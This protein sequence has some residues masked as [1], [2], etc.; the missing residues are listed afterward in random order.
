MQDHL[1][2]L[3]TRSYQ[4]PAPVDPQHTL[5]ELGLD[6]LGLAELGAELQDRFGFLVE[7]GDILPTT[8][9]AALAELVEDKGAK[10]PR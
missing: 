9:V 3:L 4:V 6:S 10:T 8:T 5:E 2:E 1:I 7:E